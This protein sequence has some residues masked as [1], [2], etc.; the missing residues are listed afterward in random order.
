[1]KSWRSEGGGWASLWAAIRKNQVARIVAAMMILW[2]LGATG[3]HLA[4]QGPG[5]GSHG[6]RGLPPGTYVEV[7]DQTTGSVLY[8]SQGT[9]PGE[10][11]P[12][13]PR[14]PSTIKLNP[15]SEGQRDAV[16]YFTAPA[17]SG[18]DR[19]RVRASSDP[20]HPGELLIVGRQHE[21]IR[22]SSALER[23]TLRVFVFLEQLPH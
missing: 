4:E 9:F 20:G 1:M 5:G 13:P 15:P 23:P 19:Y 21:K 2:V 11:A 22:E 16:R 17:T 10:E 7:R 6:P 12:P 18:D 14:L 8:Q 3:I